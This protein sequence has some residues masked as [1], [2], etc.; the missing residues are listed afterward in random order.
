[1]EAESKNRARKGRLSDE[2][3]LNGLGHRYAL[4]RG[5]YE[6]IEQE[7]EWVTGVAALIDAQDRIE[8]DRV[9][10]R[11]TMDAIEVVARHIDPTWKAGA[12]SPIRPKRRDGSS[13]KI[14]RTALAVLRREGRPM[15]VRELARAVAVDLGHQL[16][17]REIQR[18]E[19]AIRPSLDK[20]V[21]KYLGIEQGPPKRYFILAGASS[22]GSHQDRRRHAAA[23]T[24]SIPET[25]LP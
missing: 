22:F 25:P 5:R 12:I 19:L 16:E 14:S 2:T 1:M 10:M 3:L 18:F 11:R 4:L 13:G 24:P 21:G 17:Q 8:S 7:A 23:N 9:L 6:T 20:R 15:K